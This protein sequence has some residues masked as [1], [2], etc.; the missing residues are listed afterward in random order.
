MTPLFRPTRASARAAASGRPVPAAAAR[1]L[2]SSDR[3]F[4]MQDIPQQVARPI[5]GLE[6]AVTIDPAA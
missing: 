4:T 6:R 2:E 5:T 1:P 3:R